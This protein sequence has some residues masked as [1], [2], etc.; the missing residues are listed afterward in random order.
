MPPSATLRPR[1]AGPTEVDDDVAQDREQP[2][3]QRADLRVEALARPPG[4]QEGLLHGLLGEAG[5][6]ERAH[7]EPVQLTGVRGVGLTHV[8]LVGQRSRSHLQSGNTRSVYQR[9][10]APGSAC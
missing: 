9:R 6:A 2:G 5:V 3:A 10:Q 4:A 8:P 1:R 7:C